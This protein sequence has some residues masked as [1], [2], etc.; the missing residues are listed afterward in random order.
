MLHNI[1]HDCNKT[2]TSIYGGMDGLYMG[3]MKTSSLYCSGWYKYKAHI[4]S[5]IVIIFCVFVG[6][7][8]QYERVY[9]KIN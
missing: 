9:A 1:N 2:P 4:L 7:D 3:T 6:Y 8:S 5:C